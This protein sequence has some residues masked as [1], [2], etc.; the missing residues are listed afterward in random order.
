MVSDEEIKKQIK[1][2]IKGTDI[3][4]LGNKIKGKVRDVYVKNDKLFLIATDRQSAFDRNLAN[5]PFKGQVLTQ[6]SLF[7]F[8][9]TKDIVKNHVISSPDPN[10]VE[11]KKLNVFPVEVVVRGY[12]TGVTSTSAWTAYEKGERDFCGITLPE[13]LKKNQKFEEPILTPTTKDD[14]HDEKI[15][16]DEIVKSG[17]MTQEQWDFVAEKALELF[18]RGEEIAAKNG[19]ILVDTK[20]EFGYDENGEIYLIDEIHTPDSS[21][22]W[23]KKSHEEKFAKGEEPENIDKEFLR[24]WFKENCDPYKDKVLPDAPEELVVELS[25]RY[26]QLYEMITGQEFKAEVGD[27]SERIENNLKGKGLIS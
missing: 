8:E 17:R 12:I 24:L 18:Q 27:V 3:Q 11:C 20:Y 22:F 9:N 26:I 21:R 10:T 19:L 5:I 2:A 7:W 6:T 4:G 25:K 15:S 14:E 23:I 16:P 13:G 1:F